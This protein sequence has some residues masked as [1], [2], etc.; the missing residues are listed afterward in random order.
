MTATSS[1]GET[2]LHS[3]AGS[4]S[5]QTIGILIEGGAVEHVNAR[6]DL[7]D[8]PLHITAERFGSPAVAQELIDAGAD[9]DAANQWGDTP[10]H[11]TVDRPG[12]GNPEVARILVLA[13][14]DPR[15]ENDFGDTPI[16][17]A[18]DENNQEMLQILGGS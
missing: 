9:V 18:R 1:Y 7:G 6:N 4:E 11:T 13:G 14:A 12:F 8:T 17:K 3:A 5:P 2:V 10:L 15:L 16:S